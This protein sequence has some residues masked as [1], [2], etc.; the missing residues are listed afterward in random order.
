MWYGGGGLYFSAKGLPA[1]SS[2]GCSVYSTI[3]QSSRLELI[4]LDL[5]AVGAFSPAHVMGDFVPGGFLSREWCV[6]RA[7]TFLQE[8]SEIGP[9]QWG[10]LWDPCYACGELAVRCA[11]M[12][13]VESDEVSCRYRMATMLNKACTD[14]PKP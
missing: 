12:Y 9:W 6:G 1:Y 2:T 8:Q 11:V 3:L 5:E 14:L 13:I 7:C 4:C 10:R